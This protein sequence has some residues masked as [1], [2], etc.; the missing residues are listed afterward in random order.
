M[1]SC[2]RFERHVDLPYPSKVLGWMS[3]EE[4]SK[5]YADW[6][7][8]AQGQFVIK[9]GDSVEN[10]K[11]RVKVCRLIPPDYCDEQDSFYRKARVELQFIRMSDQKVLCETIIPERGGGPVAPNCVDSLMEF[12]IDV[13]GVYGINLKDGWAFIRF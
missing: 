10:G 2:C 5:V 4:R 9:T 13:I 7:Y 1:D 11:I 8:R 3:G 6:G 12:D